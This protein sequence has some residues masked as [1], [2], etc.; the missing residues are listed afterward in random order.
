M[1]GKLSLKCCALKRLILLF[2]ENH[3]DREVKVDLAF[4]QVVPHAKVILG[5]VFFKHL[6]D[7]T[8]IAGI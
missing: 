6:P 2:A 3:N 1:L 4:F 5:H 8:Y 7:P